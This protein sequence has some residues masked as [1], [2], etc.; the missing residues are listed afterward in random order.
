MELPCRTAI[1]C[2]SAGQAAERHESC[3]RSIAAWQ[4]DTYTHT[5]TALHSQGLSAP[6]GPTSASCASSDGA[7]AAS[8]AIGCS[9]TPL[10][11]LALHSQGLSAPPGP[12]SAS[13]ASSD[14]ACAASRAASCSSTPLPPATRGP[15]PHFTAAQSHQ[16]G[17]TQAFEVQIDCVDI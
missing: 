4:P 14:R 12:T 11:P 10:L 15:P 6:P 7:C 9:S 5:H 2:S 17:R 3:L 8:R 13:C 1:Q 16:G